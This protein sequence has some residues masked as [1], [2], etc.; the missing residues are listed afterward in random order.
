MRSVSADL[1]VML[2]GPGEEDAGGEEGEGPSLDG[3]AGQAVAAP[4]HHL[5]EVV[6]CCHVLKQASCKETQARGAFPTDDARES[7]DRRDSRGRLLRKH[8]LSPG[9]H[10]CSRIAVNETHPAVLVLPL[11]LPISGSKYVPFI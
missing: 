3:P 10:D 5:P 9:K 11:R 8:R 1:L 4:L 7:P 6:G 2:L